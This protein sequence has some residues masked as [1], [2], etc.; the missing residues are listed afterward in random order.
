MYK[1]HNVDMNKKNRG[2]SHNYAL[3]NWQLVWNL[4][5]SLVCTKNF[6]HDQI[7]SQ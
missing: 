6:K 3:R 5:F 1:E 2:H 4:F 7:D